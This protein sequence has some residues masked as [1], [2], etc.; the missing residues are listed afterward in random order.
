QQLDYIR[1]MNLGFDK[2]SIIYIPAKDQIGEKYNTVK[3]ELLQNTGIF[4]VT[5]QD[6]LL[7]TTLNRTTA[8]KWEGK[9]ADH[10]QDM[11]ISRVDYNFFE[12]LGIELLSGRTFSESNLSDK[13]EAFILNEEAV[14]QMRIESPV[15]KQFTYYKKPGTIIGV[16]KDTH[17]RSLHHKIEPHVF[18]VIEDLSSASAYGAVLIKYNRNNV[19]KVIT[20][21]ETVWKDMNPKVPFEYFFLDETYDNLY[22]RSQK[23]SMILG[24]FTVLAIFISCLGLLGLIS[25]IAERRTKE[26]G[27]RKVL[28]ASMLNLVSILTKELALLVGL[29]NII[30]WPIA[31][32]IMYKLLQNYAYHISIGPGVFIFSAILALIISAITISYKA[33]KAALADPVDALKYE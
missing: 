19:S 15:G 32:F 21:I 16:V 20:E 8:Y 7:T 25:F 28:G 13:K 5:A 1:T 6:Y 3:T 9:D 17:L 22:K 30:A 29:A 31:Y 23:L 4:A 12:A 27:I 11:L 26:I 14:R 24:S 18:H 33:L 2:E 10:Q